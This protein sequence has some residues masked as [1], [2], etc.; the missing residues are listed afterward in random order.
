MHQSRAEIALAMESQMEFLRSVRG[1]DEKTSTKAARVPREVLFVFPERNCCAREAWDSRDPCILSSGISPSRDMGKYYEN[2]AR[3]YLF[4][5]DSERAHEMG[6]D[7]MALLGALA[8]LRA[9]GEWFSRRGMNGT[10][11][12][13]IFGLRFPNAVGLAA[14]FDKNARAW[15]AAAALGFGHVE[16]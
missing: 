1:G 4:R 6:V 10:R 3:P 14:G 15:W 12:V 2:I 9:A 13:E 16:I 11:P 5:R 8:P 7:A